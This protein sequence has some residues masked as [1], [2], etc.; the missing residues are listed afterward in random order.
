MRLRLFAS[1]M[2]AATTCAFV[3][4]IPERGHENE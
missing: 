2:A 4:F 1:V 3:L